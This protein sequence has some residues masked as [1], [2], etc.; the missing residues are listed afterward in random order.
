[1]TQ[2]QAFWTTAK[3]QGELRGETLPPP[4]DDE[5]LVRALYSGISRGSEALVFAGHVPES[6][7]T[8]MRCPFQAGDF[9]FPVKYGYA[10]VGLVEQGPAALQGQVVFCLYPHQDRYVVPADAVIPLPDDLSTKRAV[11]GANAETALNALWDGAPRVGDRIAVVGAGVVGCL[12]AA[13]A[14]RIPGTQVQLIDVDPKKETTARVLD[15]PFATPDNATGGCDLVVHATGTGAGLG[16]A[17][18]LAGFEATLLELSW[19][20]A[21]DVPAP[22]GGAFHSQRL[23]LQSSQVGA[24]SSARRARWTHKQR[25]TKALELLRDPMFGHLVSGESRFDELPRTMQTLAG[26]PPAGTLCHRIAYPA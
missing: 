14:A 25:L 20:G 8:R 19:Y 7:R 17:I 16:T 13:L 22:L 21:G 10:S 4:G 6:E 1:M 2:A 5:V 9:P 15:V 23:T 11:L 12:V 18:A 26:D 24:V 3:M